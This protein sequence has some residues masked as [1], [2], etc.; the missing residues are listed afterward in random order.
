MSK[1][2]TDRLAVIGKNRL[3]LSFSSALIFALKGNKHLSDK[4]RRQLIAKLENPQENKAFSLL[5]SQY[6]MRAVNIKIWQQCLAGEVYAFS[7]FEEELQSRMKPLLKGKD[8]QLEDLWKIYQEV[9]AKQ[10]L[11]F[12]A[13]TICREENGFN[14][15]TVRHFIVYPHTVHGSELINN[16]PPLLKNDY[17]YLNGC[18]IDQK[19]TWHRDTFLDSYFLALMSYAALFEP[20]EIALTFGIK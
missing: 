20:N 17:I 1:L 9:Y 12:G 18:G 4:H 10:L 2:L 6:N 5:F 7:L 14:R 13:A 15:Q 3:K 8:T 16:I 11:Q 19:T